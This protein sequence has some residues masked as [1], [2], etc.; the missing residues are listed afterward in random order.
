M[1]AAA[2]IWKM[3]SNGIMPAMMPSTVALASRLLEYKTI[4]L[5]ST[6]WKERAL[7]VAKIN[8]LVSPGGKEAL[9]GASLEHSACM[10]IATNLRHDPYPLAGPIIERPNLLACARIFQTEPLWK[11]SACRCATFFI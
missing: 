3:T 11:M 7:N 1:W 2:G 10:R 9:R 5:P 8:A 4:G 6:I